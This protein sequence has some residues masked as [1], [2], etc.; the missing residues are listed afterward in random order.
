MS[1]R[2][3]KDDLKTLTF[4]NCVPFAGQSNTDANIIFDVEPNSLPVVFS[5]YH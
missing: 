5:W 2:P 4:E 1:K 3:E